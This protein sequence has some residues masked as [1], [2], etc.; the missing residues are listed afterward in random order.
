MLSKRF[1]SQTLFED[2]WL[3]SCEETVVGRPN[4]GSGDSC[5]VSRLVVVFNHRRFTFI[6]KRVTGPS[7]RHSSYDSLKVEIKRLSYKVEGEVLISLKP[8]KLDSIAEELFWLDETD[9]T[10]VLLEDDLVLKGF[11][12]HSV[13]LYQTQLFRAVDWLTQFHSA[14]HHQQLR[15]QHRTRVWQ[16]GGYWSLDKR[17]D[18]LS[19]ML[20][21]WEASTQLEELPANF[22]KRLEMSSRAMDSLLYPGFPRLP[23]SQE[24]ERRMY[25]NKEETSLEETLHRD[26]IRLTQASKVS[27][28]ML[29]PLSWCLESTTTTC[30]FLRPTLLHGDFKGENIFFTKDTS[31]CAVCDFQWTG[32][33]LG[34]MDIVSLLFSSLPGHLN[35]DHFL[36]K[37]LDRYAG[38]AC[39]KRDKQILRFLFDFA[40]VD[41]ARYVVGTGLVFQEDLFLLQ[42]ANQVLNRLDR[43]SVLQEGA[44]YEDELHRQFQKL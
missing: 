6:C 14:A 26:A 44:M 25:G 16:R 15:T 40:V 12:V 35:H 5:I 39:P 33:G 28:H 34:V 10:S 1:V 3:E 17:T 30:R 18:E 32:F 41:Y 43:G 22:A 19:K 27:T 21:R 29:A 4:G 38:S 11:P 42:Y 23:F 8:L 2:G 20:L 9:N 37:I 31:R 36:G 13:E 24:E 7:E